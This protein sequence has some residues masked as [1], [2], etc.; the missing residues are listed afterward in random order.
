MTTAD[1]IGWTAAGIFPMSYLSKKPL[2]LVSI[3]TEENRSAVCS[4]TPGET[5][6]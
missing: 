2:H 3:L 4:D 5:R 6:I 1:A